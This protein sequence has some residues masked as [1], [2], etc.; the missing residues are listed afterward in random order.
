MAVDLKA[1]KNH[2]GRNPNFEAEMQSRIDA[3]THNRSVKAHNLLARSLKL[4][5]MAFVAVPKQ[6]NKY[7]PHQGAKEQSRGGVL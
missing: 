6:P 1:L 5:M 3:Q 4:P 7:V 2:P